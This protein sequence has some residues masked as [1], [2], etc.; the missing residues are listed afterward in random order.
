MAL[1]LLYGLSMNLKTKLF[2]LMSTA[3]FAGCM[4]GGE[5]LHDENIGSTSAALEASMSCDDL[6]SRCEGEFTCFD[7]TPSADGRCLTEGACLTWTSDKIEPEEID[8][9][10]SDETETTSAKKIKYGPVITIK[11]K[12]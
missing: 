5:D 1:K 6:A 7:A 9:K 3:I 12:G 8:C 2:A 11:P 4:A 10:N